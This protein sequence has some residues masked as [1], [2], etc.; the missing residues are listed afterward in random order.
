MKG[1]LKPVMRYEVSLRPNPALFLVSN[2]MCWRARQYTAR[3]IFI[4]IDKPCIPRHERDG[5]GQRRLSGRPGG[6]GDERRV[7]TWL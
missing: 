1:M 7:G 2:G 3:I 5:R 4:E 6:E